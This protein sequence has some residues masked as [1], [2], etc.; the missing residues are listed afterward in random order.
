LEELVESAAGFGV[1]NLEP[2]DR[3]TERLRHLQ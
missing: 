2:L 3:G 1:P